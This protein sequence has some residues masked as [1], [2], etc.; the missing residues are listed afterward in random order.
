ML[1]FHVKIIDD[2]IVTAAPHSVKRGNFI[3]YRA[4]SLR[5]LRFFTA[6]AYFLYLPLVSVK[7]YTTHGQCTSRSSAQNC[8]EL[9]TRAAFSS[10]PI[11]RSAVDAISLG[12][13]SLLS[14]NKMIY[15]SHIAKMDFATAMRAFKS[16]HKDHTQNY[17]SNMLFMGR[18]HRN[19]C[20]RFRI[21]FC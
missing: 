4:T 8:H 19:D 16:I 17:Y 14:W 18:K 7:I 20:A 5:Y 2:N 6:S 3:L 12:V 9:S 11:R 15:H 21:R 1:F 10:L 13:L